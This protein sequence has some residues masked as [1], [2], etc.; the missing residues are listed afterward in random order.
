VAVEAD[1]GE[2]CTSAAVGPRPRGAAAAGSYTR[3]T[4]DVSPSIVLATWAAGVALVSALVARWRV[5]GPGFIWLA[6]AVTLALGIPAA[7]A[8]GGTWAW[9]GCVGAAIAFVVARRWALV[10]ALMAGAAMCLVAGVVA[11]GGGIGVAGGVIVMGGVTGEMMLGHWYLVDPR[12]PRRSLRTLDLIGGAGAVID[13]GVL[14]VAGAIPWTGSSTILGV[15]FVLLAVTTVVLMT[16][17]WF[18]L[19]EPGYAAVMAATGLSYLAVL[20]AIGAV[21]LGRIL[22][23]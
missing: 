19:G 12:L 2:E 9:A 4:V 1:P 13:F 7:L 15:G 16:A 18:S 22:A 21:V 14:A 3:P 17:V 23:A 8:G 20:T 11:D 5:V 10:V 6:C